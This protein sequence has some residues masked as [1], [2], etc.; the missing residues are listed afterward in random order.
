M[1]KR[2][3]TLIELLVV[4]AI[5][6]IL[7]AILLPALARARE[8]ARRSS[9]ANNLKQLGIVFKMFANEDKGQSYPSPRWYNANYATPAT[10]KY[11][12]IAQMTQVYPEYLTDLKV[13]WCPSHGEANSSFEL[14]AVCPG[15]GW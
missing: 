15:G 3:F 6:G 12:F 8:A 11:Q 14:Y 10:G 7:A 5:I 1:K 13:L 9:C 4:I 2:G